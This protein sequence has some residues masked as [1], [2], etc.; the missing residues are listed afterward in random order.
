MENLQTTVLAPPRLPAV[1]VRA[2]KGI[3]ECSEV[4]CEWEEVVHRHGP[5]AGPRV[6][7]CACRDSP[8]KETGYQLEFLS[9]RAGNVGALPEGPF[10]GRRSL[11]ASLGNAAGGMR[12]VLLRE[13]LGLR[14]WQC[15]T[16]RIGNA[17][18]G[19]FGSEW[20]IEPS[21]SP[22]LPVEGVSWAP[23]SMLRGRDY[24]TLLSASYGVDVGRVGLCLL[25]TAT[26][27]RLDGAAGQ[28]I[29]SAVGAC[30]GRRAGEGNSLA[31]VP[32]LHGEASLREALDRAAS[33]IRSAHLRAT[34]GA[35]THSSSDRRIG[36]CRIDVNGS[37]WSIDHGVSPSIKRRSSPAGR[38]SL[39]GSDLLTLSA[40]LFG[41]SC[42]V[43]GIR[44]LEAIGCVHFDTKAKLSIAAAIDA[45]CGPA[46]AMS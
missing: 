3:P 28:G 21:V 17:R 44:V 6:A 29:I 37:H 7:H 24:L 26:G 23:Q 15:A 27:C 16:K 38:P 25:E 43:A 40:A 2:G 31:A 11:R 14:G 18:I 35:R 30:Y 5:S 32:I 8:Y 45:A 12:L 10:A 34:L 4:W 33:G 41:V 22:P 9:K 13:T 36:R 19:V 42:G 20:S 1:L 39:A 46:P